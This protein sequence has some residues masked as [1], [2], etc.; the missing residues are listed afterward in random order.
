M[1]M[2]SAQVIIN[3][4]LQIRLDFGVSSVAQINYFCLLDNRM[5]RRLVL[6]AE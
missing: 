3:Q 4:I 5:T 1:K 2:F 6:Q